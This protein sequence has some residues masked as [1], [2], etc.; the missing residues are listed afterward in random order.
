MSIRAASIDVGWK[1]LGIYVEE[2]PIKIISECQ[3]KFSLIPSS[4][5]R[6]LLHNTTP[7]IQK[8]K[9]LLANAGKSLYMENIDLTN[10][11]DIGYSDEVRKN[12]VLFF[13][14]QL[15]LLKTCDFIIIEQQYYNPF[16]NGKKGSVQ[17]GTANMDAIKLG[18]DIYMWL[19]EHIQMINPDKTVLCYVEAKFKTEIVGCPRGF[20]KPKRKE[21]AVTKTK[22]VF[23]E[24][25]DIKTHASLI[26]KRN[27]V[28]EGKAR[29]L[30]DKCDAFILWQAFLFRNGIWLTRFS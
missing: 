1:N 19:F 23:V 15:H 17:K 14:Q 22:E 2:L 9:D 24:R 29:K 20:S 27:K 11:Q 18:E 4:K 6:L 21:W 5:A 13:R 28:G 25:K 10:G 16:G 3:E 8:I 7:A 30:D 12:M 26:K